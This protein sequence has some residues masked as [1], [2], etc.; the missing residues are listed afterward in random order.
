LLIN[1][2]FL[3]P[4]V[5]TASTM[6]ATNGFDMTPNTCETCETE[7]AVEKSWRALGWQ[8][9]LDGG[10]AGAALKELSRWREN[11][12]RGNGRPRDF[13]IELGL[14]PFELVRHAALP[15]VLLE[16]YDRKSRCFC[17]FFQKSPL[18]RRVAFT[19][20]RGWQTCSSNALS[21]FCPR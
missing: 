3:P 15:S 5:R 9:M 1:P 6:Y 19:V 7:L 18:V 13:P 17:F 10:P 21:V 20:S 11:D 2:L 4:G 12:R 14:P 8:M 16:Q